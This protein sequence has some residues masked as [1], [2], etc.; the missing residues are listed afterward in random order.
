MKTRSSLCRAC[1]CERLLDVLERM[2]RSDLVAE[3]SSGTYNAAK[4]CGAASAYA[5]R[6]RSLRGPEG[7]KDTPLSGWSVK[8]ELVG[9]QKVAR[10][11]I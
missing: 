6:W 3:L 2:G 10:S 9:E 1:M 11:G 8:P 5:E 4:K 7:G